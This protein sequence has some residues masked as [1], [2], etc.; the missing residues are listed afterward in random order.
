MTTTTQ[1]TVIRNEPNSV[2]CRWPCGICNGATEK[3]TY[4]FEIHDPAVLVALGIIERDHM[5]VCDECA[6]HP[7]EIPGILRERAQAL[8]EGSARAGILEAAAAQFEFTT[9]VVPVPDDLRGL[10]YAEDAFTPWMRERLGLPSVRV[11]NRDGSVTW[12][13]ATPDA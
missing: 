8:R 13:S 7:E 3:Q 6:E 2:A 4:L 9:E 1:R 11:E 5:I 10:W 12:L